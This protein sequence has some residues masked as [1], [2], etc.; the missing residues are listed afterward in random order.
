MP[1]TFVPNKHS[2]SAYEFIINGIDFRPRGE[3]ATDPEELPDEL[4]DLLRLINDLKDIA[5]MARQVGR[6]VEAKAGTVLGPGVTY[7]YGGQEV[8]WNHPYKWRAQSMMDEFLIDAVAKHP[9]LITTFFNANAVRK[10][11]IVTAAEKLGLDPEAVLSTVLY[12]EWDAE[13]RIRYKPIEVKEATDAG[14]G[15]GKGNGSD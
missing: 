1:E 2:Q 3:P 14:T 8:R 9:E 6:E 12:K 4:D 15:K 10:T 7:V 13:P 11:G 5:A